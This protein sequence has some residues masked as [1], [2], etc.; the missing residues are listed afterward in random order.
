MKRPRLLYLAWLLAVVVLVAMITNQKRG[1]TTFYGI[2]ETREIIINSE[3]PVEIKRIRV[4]PG[5]RV[6]KDELLVEFVRPELTMEINTI[7]HKLE[8]L[9]AQRSVN[10]HA[11]KTRINGLKAQKAAEVS[12]INYR[13]KQLQAQLDINRELASGLKSLDPTQADSAASAV[14]NP[15]AIRIESLRESLALSVRPV[16][17]QIDMLEEELASAE[18]PL[19]IQEESLKRALYLLLEEKNRLYKFSPVDGVI[20]SVNYKE[21]EQISPFDAILTLHT[22]TPSFIRG[23]IHEKAYQR[24]NV[25]QQTRVASMGDARNSTIGTVIGVGA[26]IIEYPPRLKEMLA[27]P[28]WGREVLIKIDEKNRLLLGEKVLIS[29]CG[30][31]DENSSVARG[32]IPD[33][34]I[35]QKTYARGITP[36]SP[37]IEEPV[38]NGTIRTVAIDRSLKHVSSIE[39]SGVIYLEDLKQYL[40][41][42]DDT[43]GNRPLLYLMDGDGVITNELVIRGIKEIRDMEAIAQ[44]EEGR[45]YIA[46]SQSHDKQGDLPGSRRQLIRVKRDRVL[47]SVDRQVLLYDLLYDLYLRNP[48]GVMSEI[49]PAGP[50]GISIDV[51]GVCYRDGSLFLGLKS[52]LNGDRAAILRISDADGLFDGNQLDEEDIAVW[53]LLDL[54]DPVSGTPAG[55]SDLNYQHESGKWYILSYAETKIDGEKARIGNLW[56]F[57]EGKKD[58]VLLMPLNRHKPEGIAHN[59]DRGTFIITFDQGR[60]HPS[61]FMFYK[62]LS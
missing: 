58:T 20:G 62:G 31:C 18:D 1:V 45:I 55:I 11:L 49:A 19:R 8:E 57:D 34:L 21:G 6:E 12:D 41:V 54:R 28:V 5:Q 15:A 14:P 27:V 16:Q 17:I 51:E 26:R 3:Y 13:I 32:L 46:S 53:A 52:P 39:A 60:K 25:G 10:T 7:S 38:N 29:L 9:G 36:Q 4:V 35:Q 23:F 61:E 24:V 2:A 43:P 33:S 56:M 44:D 42:S 47:L 50:E 30:E 37:A 48:G 22:K 59:P 40:I